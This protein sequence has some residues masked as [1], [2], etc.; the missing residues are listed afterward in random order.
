M[1]TYI[2]ALAHGHN[3]FQKQSY[4]FVVAKKSND[5]LGVSAHAAAIIA[6]RHVRQSLIWLGR[7]RTLAVP[8]SIVIT[9]RNVH[10]QCMCASAC[11]YRNLRWPK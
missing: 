5:D 6:F 3:F 1:H 4:F 2:H 10:S 9:L 11:L 7:S 8:H